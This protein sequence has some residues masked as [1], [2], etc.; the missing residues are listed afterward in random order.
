MWSGVKGIPLRVFTL[1]SRS[2]ALSIHA[3]HRSRDGRLPPLRV[4]TEYSAS[5]LGF[6]WKARS[7]ALR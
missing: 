1:G 5:R 3:A 2:S 6:R 7:P 4:G